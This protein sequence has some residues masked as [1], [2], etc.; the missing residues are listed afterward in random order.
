[1]ELFRITR[2]DNVIKFFPDVTSAC[3]SFD[4]AGQPG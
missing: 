2:L 1:M 4:A 3:E